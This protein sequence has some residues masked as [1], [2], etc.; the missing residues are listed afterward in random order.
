MDKVKHAEGCSTEANYEC[1][2]GAL[3]MHVCS[4]THVGWWPENKKCIG[5]KD[6]D[7]CICDCHDLTA[8]HHGNVEFLNNLNSLKASF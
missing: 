7:K 2:C 1:D 8:M 3:P 6:P 5:A 4:A